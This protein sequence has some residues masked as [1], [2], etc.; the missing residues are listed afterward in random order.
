MNIHQTKEQQQKDIASL[1]ETLGLF[2][3]FNDKQFSE[4]YEK[5]KHLL[6]DGE[7]LVSVGSGGYIP[8][9]NARTMIDGIEK[10]KKE[11]KKKIKEAHAEKEHILYE[12]RNHEA[13]Y[14]GS[15]EDTCK[16][17]EGYYTREEIISVYTE[18]LKKK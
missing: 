7:K 9:H 8:K 18:N 10:I 16:A 15:I 4:G 3:A 17:L 5:V 6:I 14:T 13:F 2:W 1:L 12:L 11:Y